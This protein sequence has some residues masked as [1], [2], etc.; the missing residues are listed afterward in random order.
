L[1]KIAAV[2]V[3]SL[4]VFSGSFE[5]MPGIGIVKGSRVLDTSLF[6]INLSSGADYGIRAQFNTTLIGVEAYYFVNSLEA[7]AVNKVRRLEL[8]F[9]DQ[10]VTYGLGLVLH[11]SGIIAPYLSATYGKTRFTGN[12]H[13][14]PDG[15]HFTLGLGAKF[16]ISAIGI[17]GEARLLRVMDILKDYREFSDPG[18]FTTFSVNVGAVIKIK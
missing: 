18:K 14:A 8:D 10:F 15:K 17:W 1:R 16:M 6:S 3:L 9:S 4:A 5:L 7:D 2:L 12:H 13:Y 11:G